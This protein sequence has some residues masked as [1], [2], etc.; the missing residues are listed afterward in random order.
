MPA[1]VYGVRLDDLTTVVSDAVAAAAVPD[2]V[3]VGPKGYIHDWIYVGTRGSRVTS[4]RG[5]LL[6]SVTAEQR[7]DLGQKIKEYKKQL[8]PAHRNAI[9]KWTAA[10]GMVR[11]MQ[12][13]TAS[14]DTLKHFDEALQGAPKV[15]GLVYRAIKP[16]SAGAQ[17]ADSLK[18]GDHVTI[19][20]PVSTSIDPRQAAGYGTYLY[21]IDSPAAAY[22]SGIGS[23][24]AYEKEAVLAPGQFQVSGIDDSTIGLGSITA[25]VRV[26]HLQDVTQGE[27]S[28]LPTTGTPLT[29]SKVVENSSTL[30]KVGPKGYIHGWIKVAPSAISALPTKAKQDAAVAEIQ[31]GVDI[32]N[33]FIPDIV[34]KTKYS[35]VKNP[36]SYDS[37]VMG[38][39]NPGTVKLSHKITAASAGS[40]AQKEKDEAADRGW[41]IPHDKGHSS[42]D[43]FVAHETGHAI[44][45]HM[46]TYDQA[47]WNAV[48]KA[49]GAKIS[50]KDRPY[51]GVPFE[52]ADI[53]SIIMKNKDAFTKG[54]SQF[55]ASNPDELQAE[56]WAEYTLSS[57]PRP[58]AKAYGDY[59]MKH[60][61]SVK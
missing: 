11:R 5:K 54:V 47:Q 7:Q 38:I 19:G 46:S 58:A 55:G 40:K 13:G 60:L 16:G 24:Y 1:E 61:G 4:S 18:S 21:E 31:H 56:L 12:R 26:I 14:A 3:K 43:Y 48:A 50:P 59:I 39:T 28:W 34:A 9:E 6:P 27:R 35:I 49:L 53:G 15:N 36:S 45:D 29:V 32:Q 8:T 30:I 42:A 57:H 10:R 44:S 37:D 52:Y 33:K 22:I 2:L 23:K 25:P 41:I 51:G 17:V 20:E